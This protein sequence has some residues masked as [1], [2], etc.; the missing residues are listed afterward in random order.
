MGCIRVLLVHM[1]AMLR[2]ILRRAVATQPDMSVVA[3]VADVEQLHALEA[4]VAPDIVIIGLDE[5]DLPPSCL[6]L[7]ELR[8][9]LKILILAAAGRTAILYAS[10]APAMQVPEVSAEGILQ[11]IRATVR[12]PASSRGSRPLDES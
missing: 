3:E 10:G 8:P 4:V 9:N 1:P 5:K 6:H 7:L 11:A 2:D 12:A